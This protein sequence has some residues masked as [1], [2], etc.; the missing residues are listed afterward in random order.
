MKVCDFYT[1]TDTHFLFLANIVWI[2]YYL[3]SLFHKFYGQHFYGQN[4][5]FQKVQLPPPWKSN[6]WP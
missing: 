6:G 5:L 4:S 2:L 3:N 1:H